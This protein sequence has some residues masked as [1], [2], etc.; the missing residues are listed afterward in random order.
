M[1]ITPISQE[2]F[3]EVYGQ[4]THGPFT[5]A[6]LGLDVGAAFRTP[7]TWKHH[8]GSK[9]YKKKDGTE[10]R[11]PHTACNGAL[12]SHQKMNRVGKSIRTICKD[13]VLYVTRI[14]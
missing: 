13:K 2:D 7:C 9:S 4:R 3:D 11:Y 14:K 10:T 12:S 8:T 6:L 5:T 1:E